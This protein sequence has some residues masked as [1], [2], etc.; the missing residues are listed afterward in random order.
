VETQ[1]AERSLAG[2]AEEL[3]KLRTKADAG[4]VSPLRRQLVHSDFWDS[5]VLFRH[6]RPVLLADFDPVGELPRVDDLALTLDCARSDLSAEGDRRRNLVGCAAWSTATN[7]LWTGPFLPLSAP[8]CRWPLP[9]SRC[10]RSGVGGPLGRRDGG[11]LPRRQCRT[12]AGGSAADHER[13]GPLAGHLH[14]CQHRGSHTR[15]GLELGPREWMPIGA[16]DVLELA[17]FA[18]G[19]WGNPLT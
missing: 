1:R 17:R 11:A 10:R 3:A 5:N 4:L 6:G 18:P 14:L 16:V 19:F 15:I 8:R 13:A 12:R 7:P 2:V 9:T